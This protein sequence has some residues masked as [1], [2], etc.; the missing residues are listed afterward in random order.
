MDLTFLRPLLENP[1]PFVSVYL[2]TTDTN[3]GADAQARQLHWR[4]QREELAKEHDDRATLDAVAAALTGPETFGTAGVAAFGANGRAPLTVGLPGP[5]RREQARW[6]RLPDLLPLLV[7]SP[8]RPPHLLVSANREGGEVLVVGGAA[9]AGQH[10]GQEQDV[11]GTGWP[12][13]KVKSGGWSQDRYQRSAED[14][15]QVNAKELAAAVIKAA[16]G[17]KLE[18]VIVAGDTRARELLV[19]ELPDDLRRLTVLVD[20][21]VP[22]DSAELTTAAEEVLQKLEDDDS[23][24]QLEAFHNQAGTGRAAEGLAAT[25]AALRDGQVAE[26]FIGGRYTDGDRNAL[27]LA[28]ASDPAWVGPGLADV[29]LSEAELRDRGVTDVA[30]DKVGAALVRAAAG[31]DARLFV[32]PPGGPAAGDSPLQDDIGA[33]LRFAVPGA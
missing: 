22:V 18:A 8:P 16:G 4:D 5:P 17:S 29:A 21:E 11:R 2:D 25:V 13:H 12:V 14:A 7:Q 20:K 28:W 26:L 15:W 32:V 27:E 24:R 33:L 3:R 30:E 9:S 10:S 1:G 6:S 31:T 19:S 23:R